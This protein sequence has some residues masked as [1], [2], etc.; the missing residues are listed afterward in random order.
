MSQAQLNH[1]SGALH[2]MY[3]LISTGNVVI[4]P[5][6]DR[7]KYIELCL[8]SK[9]VTVLEHTGSLLVNC[10][11]IGPHV[12]S[13]DG[14][15]KLM[16]IPRKLGTAED[17]VEVPADTPT[18]I[19]HMLKSGFELGT[20]VVILPLHGELTNFAVMPLTSTTD[21]AVF[22]LFGEH[23]VRDR[24]VSP[25][26]T[27]ERM[28]DG[29][30]GFNFWVKS[31]EG[32]ETFDELP[33]AKLAGK[34][35]AERRTARER[36]LRA[37][38]RV[39]VSP[40]GKIILATEPVDSS[41][42]DVENLERIQASFD[43]LDGFDTEGKAHVVI[44]PDSDMIHVDSKGNQLTMSPSGITMEMKEAQT[45]VVM[46]A[47]RIEIFAQNGAG[48]IH[49]N[50]SDGKVLS[51]RNLPMDLATGVLFAGS[52]TEKTKG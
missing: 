21:E 28:I 51:T 15:L 33:E 4:P 43:A 49:L 35:A 22:R 37:V 30:G 34:S 20:S 46:T 38:T 48:E 2:Q 5:Y 9:T 31:Y 40:S 41:L 42:S 10:K 45:R 23:Q 3:R 6:T 8:L 1:G 47:G 18:K 50:G 44:D 12:T 7:N 24:H 25:A 14:F 17:S 52:P 39:R 27:V 26:S 16:G 11:V 29:K 13:D 19:K 36:R 32:P